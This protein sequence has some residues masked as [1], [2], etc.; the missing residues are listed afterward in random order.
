MLL[1]IDGERLLR[2]LEGGRRL[3]RNGGSQWR[4]RVQF[5]ERES[6]GLGEAAATAGGDDFAANAIGAESNGSVRRRRKVWH[7]GVGGWWQSDGVVG[8][9][10]TW[11]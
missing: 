11:L 6:G 7:I 4:Q 10:A 9:R 1:S 5:G 2:P 3:I 8:E